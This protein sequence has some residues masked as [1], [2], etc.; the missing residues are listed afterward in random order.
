MM[1]KVLQTRES[2]FQLFREATPASSD[3]STPNTATQDT[4]QTGQPGA[5]HLTHRAIALQEIGETCV[6]LAMIHFSMRA[7][8][9]AREFAQRGA[10]HLAEVL[11]SDHPSTQQAIAFLRECTPYAL[12]AGSSAA[13]TARGSE[14]YNS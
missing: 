9:K 12:A 13:S 4:Q 7:F 11:G 8:V 6:T 3:K 2:A 1:L 5:R 14:S 10:S